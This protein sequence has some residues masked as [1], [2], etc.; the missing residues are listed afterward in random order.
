MLDRSLYTNK[1]FQ[2]IQ[3]YKAINLGKSNVGINK[4]CRTL[5]HAVLVQKAISPKDSLM[6]LLKICM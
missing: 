6:W 2:T 4:T 1:K 3:N 5:L